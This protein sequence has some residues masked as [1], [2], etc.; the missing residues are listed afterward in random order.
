LTPVRIGS[1]YSGIAGLELGLLA[2]FAEA[3]IGT[4]VAW[5]IEIEPFCL[6]VLEKHFPD[7]TRYGD[8]SEVNFPPSV[9]VLCGGFACQDVSSAGLGKG[10]G[11]ETRSG[12]TLHHLLRLID[13]T[14]A[15]YLVIENVAS[16]TK[17]WLPRVVQELRDRGYRPYAIPLSASDVGAPHRRARVFV[18]AQRKVAQQQQQGL[19]VGSVESARKE[20]QASERSGAL[21]PDPVGTILREQSRRRSGSS[22]SCK[23]QSGELGEVVADD[24]DERRQGQ[25][26]GGVLDGE[27][28]ALGHDVDGC[29]VAA[30]RRSTEPR[31]VL[32]AD[33]LPFD[34]AGHRWPAGRGIAQEVFEEPRV[35]EGPCKNRPAKL[36]ALGNAVVPQCSLVV[37]RALLALMYDTRT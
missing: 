26:R 34:V 24:D 16:G 27:R 11:M 5:Q 7:T 2:A 30:G 19:E 10:L 9:D 21:V 12:F 23:A 37:G 29:D 31:M 18:V 25:R 3:G 15:N 14:K 1:V 28:K 32:P 35:I 13:E 22:G 20:L 4:Q 17:R 36:R 8:V 6:K 33:G